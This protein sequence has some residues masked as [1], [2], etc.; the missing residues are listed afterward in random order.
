ML[1]QLDQAY[2]P[3]G[4]DDEGLPSFIIEAAAFERAQDE[5]EYLAPELLKG[6]GEP[7]PATDLYAF[8]IV[9]LECVSVYHRR[10]FEFDPYLD[11]PGVQP[12]STVEIACYPGEQ[13]QSWFLER[14]RAGQMPKVPEPVLRYNPI[15]SSTIEK[16]LASSPKERAKVSDCLRRLRRCSVKPERHL[17]MRYEASDRW[18]IRLGLALSCD[19]GAAAKFGDDGLA[20]KIEWEEKQDVASFPG[21]K[22]FVAKKQ[23]SQADIESSDIL[24]ATC[25]SWITESATPWC[26][27]VSVVRNLTPVE[28]V[29]RKLDESQGLSQAAGKDV[30]FD[31]AKEVELS[32]F[33]RAKDNA[34]DIGILSAR[35]TS[36]FRVARALD[37]GSAVLVYRPQLDSDRHKLDRRKSVV[38][39]LAKASVLSRKQMVRM[40]GF[41]CF[42]ASALPGGGSRCTCTMAAG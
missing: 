5:L 36:F 26:R 24:K 3:P 28:C 31:V 23:F 38:F 41:A 16:C 1:G 4:N 20:A 30:Y 22:L 21:T 34:L 9:L 33:H 2:L 29:M 6:E 32:D 14:V 37:D 15:V 40:P 18:W 11:C 12:R 19:Q 10:A 17:G 39:D 25:G 7:G 35:D 8:G 27:S 42:I 13:G